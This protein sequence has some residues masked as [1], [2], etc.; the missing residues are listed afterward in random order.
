MTEKKS[1]VMAVDIGYSNLKGAYGYV[2]GDYTSFIRPASA[3]P[4]ENMPSM[5]VRNNGNS[6]EIRVLVDDKPWVACVD[7]GVLEGYSRELNH[8]FTSSDAYRALLYAA[9]QTP[10]VEVIDKLVTGLPMSH[11]QEAGYIEHLQTLITGK[12]RISKGR[13]VEVKEVEVLPQ[14]AGAFFKYVIELASEANLAKLDSGFVAVCDPGFFSYDFCGFSRGS[15]SRQASGTSLEAMSRLIELT[16]ELIH[17]DQSVPSS[18]E[19]I[20]VALQT[21]KEEVLAGSNMIKLE[22][23]LNEAKAVTAKKAVKEMVQQFRGQRRPAFI[24][25]AGGG[26][27]L[28]RSAVEQ[29]Y[30]GIE[31]IN[32]SPTG[33]V[34]G[35]WQRGVAECL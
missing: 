21:G 34:E 31:I 33:I 26:G 18:V 13:S 12:H 28:Y 22:P 4:R 35:F 25:M 20:E 16:N 32:I 14:P 1:F 24:I 29:E 15:L 9:I 11:W 10:G 2:G 19:E 3:G 8:K 17:E 30:P 23:F 7:P 27:E 6:Q 5:N